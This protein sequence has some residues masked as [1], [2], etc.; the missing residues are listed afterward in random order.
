MFL[1]SHGDADCQIREREC[2]HA[3]ISISA[4]EENF[5]KQKSRNRWLNLGDGNNAFFHKSV[6][7]RNSS[8]LI[9]ILKDEDGNRVE[10]INQIKELAIGFYQKLLGT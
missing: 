3:Y 5:L 2:L 1:E 10:D 8:N 4:A 6:K 7:A 9:K